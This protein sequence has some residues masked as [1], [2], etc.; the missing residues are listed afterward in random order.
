MLVWEHQKDRGGECVHVCTYQAF[1]K[2]EK[3]EQDF[4]HV[5]LHQD[6]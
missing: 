2:G 3:V 4:E 1:S 5:P 6:I